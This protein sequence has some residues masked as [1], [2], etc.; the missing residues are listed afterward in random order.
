[1]T[2]GARSAPLAAGRVCTQRVPSASA[3]ARPRTPVGAPVS[4]WSSA[5]QQCRGERPPA[6]H[7]QAVGVGVK[8]LDAD[9]VGAG[10]QVGAYPLADRF[11]A[12][13]GDLLQHS[14]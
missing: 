5:L 12:T 14:S 3:L 11:R 13:P 8:D 7:R 1:V 6:G 2:A 9:V 10:V 4:A